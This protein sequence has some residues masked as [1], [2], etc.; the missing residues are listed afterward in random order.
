MQK[1]QGICT[2]KVVKN[3][4]QNEVWV[5]K[6]DLGKHVLFLGIK[7]T[8]DI[9]GSILGLTISLPIIIWTAYKIRQ[10]EPKGPVFFNQIRVGKNG[11]S[12]RMYKF[13][14]MCV[15]AEDKLESLLEKNEIQGAMF[16]MRE[17][18]RVTQ[19]GKF[20]REKSI[21][22][23]PQ[24]WN[25]L[26]GDMSLVGPR[27]PLEREVAA[28]DN[29]DMQRL[30]TKP[31]CSGLWQISGRNELDFKEMVELD[32]IYISHHSIFFDLKII[33]KTVAIM[34]HSNGAY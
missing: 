24:L 34:F 31:G 7:R 33:L 28:Y 19:I 21:D 26:K 23:L 20:I 5:D 12:F 10:E 32:L 15:D 29:Y 16:K 2:K 11:K 25:V 1:D 4:I 30:F 14:S 6:D 3:N 17:D 27:P 9:F 18:P 22:E 8:I 13:R